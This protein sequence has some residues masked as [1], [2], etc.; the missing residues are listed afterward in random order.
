MCFWVGTKGE[1]VEGLVEATTEPERQT[2][3]F[4][5]IDFIG[6]RILKWLIL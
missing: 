3:F 6:R 1:Q 4:Y 2:W 5:N